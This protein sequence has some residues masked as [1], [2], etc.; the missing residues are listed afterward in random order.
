MG[1]IL[2]F[3]KISFGNVFFYLQVSEKSI[4]GPSGQYWLRKVP[5]TIILTFVPIRLI[6][7]TAVH[8]RPEGPKSGHKSSNCC[9]SGP[10]DLVLV[11]IDAE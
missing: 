1:P 5:K 3:S 6:Y 2:F 8:I 4:G 7:C 11:P 9:V 10:M